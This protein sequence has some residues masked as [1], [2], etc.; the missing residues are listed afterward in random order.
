MRAIEKE[1]VAKGYTKSSNPDFL[2]SIFTKS[3]ERVS[4]N[5]NNNFG[6]GWG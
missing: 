6:W 3:R 1:L 5:N 2:V 4:I